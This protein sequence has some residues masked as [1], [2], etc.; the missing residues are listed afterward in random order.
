[1]HFGLFLNLPIITLQL[2]NTIREIFHCVNEVAWSDFD[3][4]YVAL[5]VEANK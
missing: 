2:H 1:M 3:V 5:F 4:A